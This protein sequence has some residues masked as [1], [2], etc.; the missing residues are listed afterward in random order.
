MKKKDKFIL[1]IKPILLGAFTTFFGVLSII[2]LLL[3]FLPS[4]FLDEIPIFVKAIILV[5]L[6][7]SILTIFSILYLFVLNKKMVWTRGENKV[8]AMYGDLLKIGFNLTKVTKNIVVIPVNSA[9]DTIVEEA[10]EQNP[11]P[12]VSILT[13]HGKWI[14]KFLQKENITQEELNNRIQ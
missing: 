10:G 5:S 8:Y 11:N 13:I 12:L 2:G 4:N 9:F 14:N 3:P 1:N 6:L 7:L